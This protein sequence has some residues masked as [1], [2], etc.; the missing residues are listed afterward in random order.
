M[1]LQARVTTSKPRLIQE[2]QLMTATV[3][4]LPPLPYAESALEPVI[5]ARTVQIHYRKH[6]GGYIDAL[7]RLM[8]GTPFADLSLTQLMMSI[9]G[10]AEHVPIFNNAAQAWNH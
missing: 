5:S 3:F 7:N 2:L 8:T 4:A 9:A 6:H 1:N 10:Q